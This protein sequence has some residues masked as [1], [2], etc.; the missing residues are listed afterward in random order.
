MKSGFFLDVVVAQCSSILELL[1][2]EN[3][4][5]L[6]GWDSFL[7]LD[8]C[9]DVFNGVSWFNIKGDGLSS[10]S[11]DKDLHSSSKSENKMEGGLFLNVVIGEGSAVF[12]LL[13]SEDESLLVG[14]D[15]FFVLDLGLNIFN[16]VC[17]ID[18]K[19]DCFSCK[20]LYEN[21]HE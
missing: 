14:W 18:I 11:L 7:V 13:S 3:E 1:S 15:A 4:S 2:C 6:V 8:L 21:L 20:G 9:F 12:Q 10:E 16:S 19:S 17:W 5:L